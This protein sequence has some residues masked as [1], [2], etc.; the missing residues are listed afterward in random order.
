MKS[1]PTVFSIDDLRQAK[2]RTTCWDGVRN[3]QARNFLRDDLHIGD[4][5]FFYH[6]NTDPVG[7]AG[8]AMVVRAGYPDPTAFD[9][10][11]VHYDP[12]SDAAR[13]T[14]YAV[15]VKFVRACREI[16]TLGRLKQIPALK[17]MMVLQR[18]RLSVQPVSP[19]Q[20][21][22]VLALPEWNAP[23]GV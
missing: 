10:K 13:P 20:W 7:I 16:I 19:E 18:T 1:E 12:K 3:Y 5:V 2:G 9:R 14:W 11:D 17:T 8:E 4:G 22:I 15:D 21:R 23:S 6:S